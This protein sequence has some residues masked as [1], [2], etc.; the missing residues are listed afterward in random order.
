[1]W[2]GLGTTTGHDTSI[3]STC[4]VYALQ[5]GTYTLVGTGTLSTAGAAPVQ[6]TFA[7]AGT[8]SVAYV[9]TSGAGLASGYTTCTGT[10]VV[11]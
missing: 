1:M 9:I 11:S 10:I 6:C 8:F 2:L 3:G 5:S 7:T 4:A